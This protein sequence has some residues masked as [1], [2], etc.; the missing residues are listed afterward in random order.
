MSALWSGLTDRVTPSPR[1]VDRPRLRPVSR[2]Q[3]RL[4]RIPFLMVLAGLL[5]L[6]MVGL[7]LL[8][9]TLQNQAFQAKTLTRQA[10]ELSYQQAELEREVDRAAAPDE[11]A[12]RASALD[13]RANTHTAY[14]VLPDGKVLGTPEKVSGD[15][16][17]SS[18]VKTP[19]EVAAEKKAAEKK[20]AEKKAAEKKAA[21]KKAAEKK[22]AEKKA[23]EKKAAEKKAAE[24][25]AAEKKAAEKKAAE[26]EKAE[27][28]EEGVG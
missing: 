16:L 9:T 27:S 24:K 28:D 14:V 4:S 8:N 12:R 21:E 1:R 17:P 7:L 18:I 15:E 2:K 19:E 26:K 22:A 5:G 3:P 13:M 11:L 6:G 25:K 10:T 23:A 20:A